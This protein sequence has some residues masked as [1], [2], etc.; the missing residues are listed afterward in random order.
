MRRLSATLVALNFCALPGA[1]RTS[2]H[3]VPLLS[4]QKHV[5]F[6]ALPDCS[7][8]TSK[9]MHDQHVLLS[10]NKVGV[11]APC[12]SPDELDEEH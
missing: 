6:K 11:E 1:T 4:V 5:F 8:E 9:N 7:H 10:L 12:T 2:W 3:S